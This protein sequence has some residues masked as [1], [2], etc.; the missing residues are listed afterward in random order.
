MKKI[1]LIL[2][3]FFAF[4]SCS[5]WP[6]L[7]KNTKD[8]TSVSGESLFT[9][10]Q[11]NLFFYMVTPNVNLNIWR[12]IA[13]QWTETTYTDEANYN[14]IGR[15]IPDNVW[16]NYR[17]ALKNFKESSVVIQNT[18]YVGENPAVKKN[19]LAIIEVMMV[20]TYSF[21]VETFGNVPYSQSLDINILQPVYDD[22]LTI[23]KDLINRLNVAISDMD[24][25]Y[26]SFST[27][28][29]MYQG[30]MVK[31]LKFANS[32]KLHMGMLLA[33]VDEILAKTTVEE[34]APN[35]ISSN[36]ENATIVYLSAQ[37]NTNPIYADQVATGRRDFVAANTLVDT[38]NNWE[39]P[40]RPFY[41]TQVDTSTQQGVIKLAY[42]GGIY[43]VPNDYERYSH[44]SNKIKEPTFE[45]MIFDLAQTEFL[46]AEAV[47]RG[48]SVGG[49]AAGHYENG[50]RAS[51]SYWGG[52]E[53]EVNTYLANP[54]ITYSTAPGTYKQ[55]IGMQM[56]IALYN[57]GFEAWT[58]WRRNDF[59]RLV[60]PP[61]AVSPI[62]VRYTYPIGEQTLNRA[63]WEAASAAIGGD[64]VT[65]K[66]FWDKY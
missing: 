51:I 49:T 25:A 52:T 26:S 8:P 57:R 64:L 31:W 12:M 7:N 48:F 33:D 34:A 1:F 19:K 13:Q 41:F 60:A 17:M 56:W 47:E 28:D 54:K 36:S 39:D 55:K 14:L 21:L 5:K 37:P 10:G 22:G 35:V 9:G 29:N 18:T 59:P 38:M 62:P 45:G 40:R 43:G 16:M 4:S 27:G 53:E 32:L 46:L 42:L 23:C 50:V 3:I 20:F 30:N 6:D 61:D 24:P 63:N 66:L 15:W 44:I 2:V 58:Q 11:T 65:T